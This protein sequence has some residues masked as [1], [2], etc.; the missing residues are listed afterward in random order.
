MQLLKSID[1]NAPETIP[2][3]MA[4][5]LL[6]V[7]KVCPGRSQSDEM[8]FVDGKCLSGKVVFWFKNTK[9]KSENLYNE[10]MAERENLILQTLSGLAKP[11]SYT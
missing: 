6:V 5:L 4:N 11:L 1:H 9:H 10:L 3:K 7:D 2:Q 8:G